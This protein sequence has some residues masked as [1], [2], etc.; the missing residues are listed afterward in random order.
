M[1]CVTFFPLTVRVPEDVD[2]LYP[3][4]LPIEYEYVP[5]V[6][7][8]VIV[9]VLED[10]VVPFRVIDHEVPDGRPVSVKVTEYVTSLNATTIVAGEEPSTLADPEDGGG[11]YV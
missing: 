3:E 8:N 10:S 11:L 5:L 6:M 4:I 1:D 2:M 7:E 9:L